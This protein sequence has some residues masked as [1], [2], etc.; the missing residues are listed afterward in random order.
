[1]IIQKT[2]RALDSSPFTSFPKV[3]FEPENLDEN[4]QDV[5]DML[6]KID[7]QLQQRKQ[8]QTAL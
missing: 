4:A 6:E 7:T 2:P 8:R 3:Q 5:D 1:M